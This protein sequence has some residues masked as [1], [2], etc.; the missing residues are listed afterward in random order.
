M[1]ATI[2]DASPELLR[3]VVDHSLTSIY[4]ARAVRDTIT[5]ELIDF[6]IYFCNPAF[7]RRVRLS[8]NELQAQTVR[9]LFP[10]LVETGFF[11][12]YRQ[13]VE[14]GEPFE[15]EQEYPGPNG[16]F[17]YQ[18]AVNKLD[19]G[20]VVNF[21]NITAYK[22]THKQAQHAVQLLDEIVQVMPNGMVIAEA[23]R[24]ASVTITEYKQNEQ[25]V[26]RQADLVNSVLN[27]TLTAFAAFE[28]VYDD[29][30]QLTDFRFTL[31]NQASLDLLG[32]PAEE[33]YTKTICDMN[34]ALRGTE[35]F[36][37]YMSV[38]ETG[39]PLTQERQIGNNWFLV[40]AVRF[41]TNGLLTSSINITETKQARERLA[42]LNEQLRH[43]NESLD[44]FASVA[45]HDLQEPLRKIKS[46]GD[47]LLD[48]YGPD[49][50][51]GLT[52]LQRIQSAADRMQNLIQDLLAYSRLANSRDTEQR[53]VNLGQLVADVLVDLEVAVAEKGA[54]V[55][56]GELPILPGN[57]L[58][59]RQVFQNLLSNALKFTQ[60]GRTP[61]IT[62]SARPVN[63]S[64]LPGEV[65][66]SG[67]SHWQITIADNGIGFSE[68]YREK[69]FGAFERLHGKNSTYAGTGVGL[70][71]VRRV[72][73]NHQGSVTAHA[74]EGEGATFTLYLPGPFA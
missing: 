68:K 61:R 43:S 38:V 53:P 29:G 59:L 20:I 13:V 35:A 45:S 42:Q 41:N 65:R 3:A 19:D 57:A 39:E 22:Q 27:T 26:Q 67:T 58:Q 66:L 18:T 12:R 32:L 74:T 14:T 54:V 71:I 63:T 30:G 72:M 36:A 5:G 4:A 47:L 15:G 70:A 48:Q 31:A 62:V 60:P 16:H 11:D 8:E 17:W 51:N 1:N 56:V 52:Y 2:T 37:R 6:Q 33:L 50:G 21:I 69:I 49:L 46:F 7:C 23:M 55:E 10:V 64:E 28:P 44:Q 9:T 25:L 40:S 24:D 34:P 73:D